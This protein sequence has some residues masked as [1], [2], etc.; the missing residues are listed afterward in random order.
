MKIFKVKKKNVTILVVCLK[1]YGDTGLIHVTGNFIYILVV[2]QVSLDKVKSV[3]GY[4]YCLSLPKLS[5]G[6]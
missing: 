1:G 4:A 2:N 5:L 3:C 6:A